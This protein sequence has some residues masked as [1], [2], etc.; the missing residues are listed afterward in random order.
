MKFLPK[1][2][3]S[4][5]KGKKF[6]ALLVDPEKF[7][8]DAIVEADKARVDFIFV[9]GSAVNKKQFHTCI[10][11]IR[12]TTK[13]P[14]II[15]PGSR[16]QVSEKAD[17]ILFLSL[18]SGRNPDFLIGEHVLAAKKLKASQLEIIPTGYILINGGKK[19]STQ[20]I[21]RTTPIKK[22]DN[23]LAAATAVAGELLGMKLIYLEGGSG[24]KNSVSESMINQ[25]KRS[26]SVPLIVGGGIDSPEKA[27]HAMKAGADVI[28]VGNGAEKNISIIKEIA[29]VIKTRS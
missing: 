22:T 11:K 18:I 15:F 6:F 9:G 12:R 10:K 21:T 25:V 27:A 5:K 14:L 17:A 16:E 4:A 1:I 3:S 2:I 20:K 26:I 19:S 24:A 7:C 29:E 13:I 23:N 8:F 28:V